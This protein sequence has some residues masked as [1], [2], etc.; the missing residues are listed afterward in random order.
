VVD[1]QLERVICLNG[2]DDVM[3]KFVAILIVAALLA[4]LA[5]PRPGSPRVM[6]LY[7]YREV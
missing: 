2:R 4:V 6:V 3:S 7:A 5:G 1:I